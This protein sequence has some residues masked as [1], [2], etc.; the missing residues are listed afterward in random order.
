MSA[1][2]YNR[3]IK[4]AIKETISGGYL[5]EI[6]D[7][8]KENNM[9]FKKVDDVTTIKCGSSTISISRKIIIYKIDGVKI[10]EYKIK[11]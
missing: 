10:Y 9:R 4:K 2:N 1:M 11:F 6:L 8:I 7:A 3:L 5:L